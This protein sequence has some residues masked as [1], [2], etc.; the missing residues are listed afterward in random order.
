MSR[1]RWG[2]AAKGSC[3]AEQRLKGE[4]E[5]LGCRDEQKQ[6]GGSSQWEQQSRAEQRLKGEAHAVGC[7]EDSGSS[8]RACRAEER[9]EGGRLYIIYYILYI[10]YYIDR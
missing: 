8:L 1:S 9:K 2:A 5:A 7:R 4:A 3:R 6:M 10:I